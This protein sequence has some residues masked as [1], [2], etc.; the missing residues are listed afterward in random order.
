MANETKPLRARFHRAIVRRGLAAKT[1]S[2]YAQWI[3]RYIRFHGNKHPAELN[4][5]HVESFLEHLAVERGVSTSTLKIAMNALRFFFLHVLD[6]PF[7]DI[8][9]KFRTPARTRLPVVLS[10]D[11]VTRLIDQLRGKYRLMAELMYGA[12]L[13]ASECCGLR[14]QDIDIDYAEIMV[15]H[16]KGGK[17]R[18]TLLPHKLIPELERQIRRIS[19]MRQRDI[20]NGRGGVPVSNT[21]F[22]GTPRNASELRVW[23][24]FPA[25]KHVPD[26]QTGLWVRPSIHPTAL[27]KAIRRAAMRASLQKKVTS[28]SLR[29]SFA[30]HLLDAGYDLRT[31]QQLLGHSQLSTTTIY[32]HVLN[33]SGRNVVSPLDRTE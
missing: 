29:H 28:H 31:I 16:G 24:L 30:T 21:L 27:R 13:R 8:R 1:E 11:E 14:I 23:F 12:G 5:S 15:R 9:R 17:D 10:K 2:T 25:S 32:T 22:G 33:K 18:R 19:I 20:E 4:L 3:S 6:K 7:G 26:S